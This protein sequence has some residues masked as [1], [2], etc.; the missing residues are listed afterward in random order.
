MGHANAFLFD[1]V[2]ANKLFANRSAV[3]C[4]TEINSTAEIFK[5]YVLSFFF[6]NAYVEYF[7]AFVE[8]LLCLFLVPLTKTFFY[9]NFCEGKKVKISWQKSILTA[10]VAFI[11]IFTQNWTS[12]TQP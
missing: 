5:L 4:S 7:W 3:A 9:S 10:N 12:D 1:I 11:K 6:C 8:M 2:L